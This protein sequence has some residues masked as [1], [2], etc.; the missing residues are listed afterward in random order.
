LG[1]FEPNVTV[2]RVVKGLKQDGGELF[3]KDFRKA[4]KIQSI[5]NFVQPIKNCFKFGSKKSTCCFHETTS[6]FYQ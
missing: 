3:L 4:M 5:E 6:C 1:F 2:E